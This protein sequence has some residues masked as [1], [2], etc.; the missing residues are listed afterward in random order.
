[1]AGECVPTDAAQAKFSPRMD[2]PRLPR[3]LI[4]L[5]IV[6]LF[7][8]V[9]G[10]ANCFGQYDGENLLR[11]WPLNSNANFP[12]TDLRSP[13][14]SAPHTSHAAASP[15]AR[16]HQTQTLFDNQRRLRPILPSRGSNPFFASDQP[17]PVVV[18]WV[19]S[20]L[21][22]QLLTSD[23]LK[24]WINQLPER[25]SLTAPDRRRLNA[26][27]VSFLQED[28]NAIDEKIEQAKDDPA[29][30]SKP[31]NDVQKD[32]K[33]RLETI[34]K[35]IESREKQFTDDKSIDDA[36]RNEFLNQLKAAKEKYLKAEA[37]FAALVKLTQAEKDFEAQ[38]AAQQAAYLEEKNADPSPVSK[39][40]DSVD[41]LKAALQE[42]E[43]V[44]QEAVD[45]QSLIR[46]KITDRESRIADL[47]NLKS[48]VGSELSDIKAKV[49]E[50]KQL[51]E[52][53]NRT[54]QNLIMDSRQL[55][56]EIDNKLVTVE[57]KRLGQLSKIQPIERDVLALK[58]KRLDKETSLI[59]GELEKK[60]QKQIDDQ[61]RK[62]KQVLEEE[63]TM[64]TPI[65]KQLAEANL[66]LTTKTESLI[67]DNKT[68]TNDEDEVRKQNS[69]IDG[70]YEKLKQYIKSRGKIASGI[71]LIE[72]RRGLVSPG[73]SRSRLAE[74]ETELQAS[75]TELFK[76]KETQDRL[77]DNEK[78]LE[79]IAVTPSV[80]QL[81]TPESEHR[82]RDAMGI[83]KQLIES[84][85]QYVGKLIDEYNT[86]ID[87][88]SDLEVMHK[89]LIAK[90]RDIK[91]FSDE[92]ALWIRSAEPL[93]FKELKDCQ[94]AIAHLSQA[95]EW[96]SA[97]IASI[98]AKDSPLEAVQRHFRT[99]P[100]DLACL[101]LFAGT[102]FVFQRRL[103][104]THA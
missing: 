67:A 18:V 68:L 41:K 102:L 79:E 17:A 104:W 22:E 37:D 45:A 28:G 36:T 58:I 60:L 1:M 56:A 9:T 26:R 50:L 42:A 57:D 90:V 43:E 103:R 49:D 62:D 13:R 12:D 86:H 25:D 29:D 63:L 93:G 94:Q 72:H 20:G 73:A 100:Y 59:Q 35:R 53:P 7:V 52:G 69:K 65:L 82:Y 88:I 48:E 8:A 14:E 83:A 6:A 4:E 85:T 97:F 39:D 11:P 89:K 10:H 99:R 92:N 71:R 70:E 87:K 34:N 101:V 66:A 3:Q 24:S 19:N 64:D 74:L 80:A 15:L 61:K 84:Q 16:A 30:D 77:E 46:Q 40:L 76:L 81:D 98:L 27:Q 55:S 44:L 95:P 91:A 75:R 32:F 2:M 23:Q 96:G 38:L 54:L 21:D 51:P 47:R 31:L 5:Y 33:K 78:I